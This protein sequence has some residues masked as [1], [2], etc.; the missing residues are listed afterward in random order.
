LERLSRQAKLSAGVSVDDRKGRLYEWRSG[1]KWWSHDS[2]EAM[3]ARPVLWL[4]VAGWLFLGAATSLQ[5]GSWPDALFAENKHDF[6]MVPRGVKVRH[7]FL[8]VNRL[9]EPV[10]ILNLRPSCGCT[11]GRANVSTVAPGQTA[12]IEA[13]M[14]TRN[15]VGVKSTILFVSLITASGREGEARLGVSSN[16]LS[17]IVLNPGSIDFGTVVRGQSPTQTLTIDR[18][19]GAGWKFERMVTASKALNGQLTETARTGGSVSYSLSLSLKP[20]APAGALR[21]E[22][23]LM[24]NDLEAPSIPIMVTALIRGDLSA[25]PSVLSLGQVHSTAGAQGR[26]ILRASRPFTIKSIEGAGDGFST[27]TPDTSRQ[28]THVVTVA[29]KPEEGTTRGDLRRVFRVHTD[30]ADEPPVDLTATL[31]IDP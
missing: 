18:I 4:V 25:V 8:L 30:L 26:F 31:H 22:L 15:F 16:I 17:D 10:T 28:S 20:D 11:S 5:A 29:Y 14:D 6:G 19:N 24:S 1:L 3:M 13:E 27:S 21:E 9:A 12:V 2:Q 7:D 23:R